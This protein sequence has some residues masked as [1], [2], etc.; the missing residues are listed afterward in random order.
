MNNN[1]DQK[2]RQWKPSCFELHRCNHIRKKQINKTNITAQT[3]K[4]NDY[5]FLKKGGKDTWENI[6]K[7]VSTRFRVSKNRTE[8]TQVLFLCLHKH[9]AVIL[10]FESIVL[11]QMLEVLVGWRPVDPEHIK[12]WDLIHKNSF[13][14]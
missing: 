5:V 6:A 10:Y 3:V 8:V 1:N 4:Q 2:R 12:R 13:I 14:L 9:N 11:T 7:W